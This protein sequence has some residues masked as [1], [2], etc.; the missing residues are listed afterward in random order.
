M[1]AHVLQL[2]FIRAFAD[3]GVWEVFTVMRLGQGFCL[4]RAQAQRADQCVL[5]QRFA[6]D[7]QRGLFQCLEA[8]AFGVEEGAIHI[9]DG[10]E[11]LFTLKEKHW[12]LP[13]VVA[14][15]IPPVTGEY[16]V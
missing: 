15:D 13:L 16:G 12:V 8:Q 14:S 4:G 1:I 7:F 9:E 3:L 5:A 11:N 6:E 10:A 2:K